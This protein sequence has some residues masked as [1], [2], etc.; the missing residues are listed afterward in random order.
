MKVAKFLI[1]AVFLLGVNLHAEKYSKIMQYSGMTDDEILVF[2]INAVKKAPCR[3]LD[4]DLITL[5]DRPNC[6][7]DKKEKK[8]FQKRYKKSIERFLKPGRNYIVTLL[9]QNSNFYTCDLSDERQNFRLLLVKNGYAIP[10]KYAVEALKE[11]HEEAVEKKRGMYSD[12]FRD[13]TNCIIDAVPIPKK[14][15]R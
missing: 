4:I 3:L 15:E 2:M 14:E 9:S 12:E 10:D 11:A 1:L 13:V 8:E 7:S 5:N 6:I